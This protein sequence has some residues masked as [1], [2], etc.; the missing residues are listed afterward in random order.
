MSDP[1]R[2]RHGI[3][4]KR[5]ED[6]IARSREQFGDVETAAEIAP[7]PHS[8]SSGS[9]RRIESLKREVVSAGRS[10]GWTALVFAVLSWLIW[11]AFMGITAAVFGYFAFFQGSRML[12]GI[13]MAMG[14]L[15]AAVYLI[16]LPLY[17][18]L[19]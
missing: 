12:G 10:L 16:L 18:M 3:R 11:P 17:L 4:K 8:E 19:G 15:A 5:H 2:R 1:S 14:G 13:A 9:Q 6:W 7:A